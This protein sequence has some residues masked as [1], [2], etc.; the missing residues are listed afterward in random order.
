MI[1][2]PDLTCSSAILISRNTIKEVGLAEGYNKVIIPVKIDDSPY[3][4]SLEY[5]LCNRHWVQLKDKKGFEELG[6]E[7]NENIRFYLNRK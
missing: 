6:Q 3:H 5:D 4:K 1:H 2:H 7:L